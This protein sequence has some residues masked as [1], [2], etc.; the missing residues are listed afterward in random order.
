MLFLA[1]YSRVTPANALGTIR[2]TWG[3]TGVPTFK[4]NTLLPLFYLFGPHSAT[5]IGEGRHCQSE[6]V[7]VTLD[8][9]VHN[10]SVVVMGITWFQLILS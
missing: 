2:G 4:E 7:F 8:S 9:L 5:F 6:R 10:M 3:Q 1:L